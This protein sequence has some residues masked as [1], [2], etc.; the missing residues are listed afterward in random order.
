[1][2]VAVPV[3]CREEDTESDVVRTVEW[4]VP[5]DR[6]MMVD[7]LHEVIVSALRGHMTAVTVVPSS[8]ETDTPSPRTAWVA[9]SEVPVVGTMRRPSA[10]SERPY[11]AESAEATF[12]TIAG[13]VCGYC[14]LEW[15][16]MH[17]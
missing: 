4:V 3:A 8:L 7:H 12:S 9:E 10:Q 13:I 11:Q 6:G 1:M 14:G 17:P 5:A 16:R 2:A 15:S